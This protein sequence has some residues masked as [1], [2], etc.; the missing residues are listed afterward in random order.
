MSIFSGAVWDRKA[1]KPE[2]CGKSLSQDV[3]FTSRKVPYRCPKPLFNE[4]LIS[5]R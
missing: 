1:V 5:H 4:N 3:K 2:F